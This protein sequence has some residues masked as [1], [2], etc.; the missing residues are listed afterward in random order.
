M[1]LIEDI[2]GLHEIY[3]NILI[4][5]RNIS[6]IHTVPSKVSKRQHPKCVFQP[7]L[8]NLVIRA[9]RCMG[10]SVPLVIWRPRRDCVHLITDLIECT[11]ASSLIEVLFNSLQLKPYTYRV[12]VLFHNLLKVEEQKQK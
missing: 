5:I 4:N 3:Y 12:D 7:K 11:V 1:I 9:S 6:Q 10:H 8:A 2:R